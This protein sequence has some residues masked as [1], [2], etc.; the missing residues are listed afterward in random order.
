MAT[1]EAYLK[2]PIRVHLA[3]RYYV[4]WQRERETPYLHLCFR[5]T[6]PLVARF[7]WRKREDARWH[8]N[9]GR[10][11]IPETLAEDIRSEL[12]V[13]VWDAIQKAEVPINDAQHWA[14]Y[15]DWRF[16]RWARGKVNEYVREGIDTDPWNHEYVQVT[17]RGK[18]AHPEEVLPVL[19]REQV[20]T[21]AEERAVR[22]LGERLGDPETARKLIG[23]ILRA[24]VPVS[25][26]QARRWGY[27]TKREARY[28]DGLARIHYR[29]A[30]YEV[31]Q[32]LQ[33]YERWRR[34]V[35]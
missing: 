11:V 10:F 33:R 28:L 18:V 19:Y 21:L 29:M 3:H 17:T 4:L 32:G 20:G 34:A 7:L 13:L 8:F 24:P 30:L 12:M 25:V 23:I 14:N 26:Y 15:L 6:L 35:A 2:A 27:A 16:Y 1:V 5:F 22:T 31:D 9:G